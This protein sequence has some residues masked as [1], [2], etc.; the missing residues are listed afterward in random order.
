MLIVMDPELWTDTIEDYEA[1]IFNY[2]KLLSNYYSYREYST[3]TYSILNNQDSLSGLGVSPIVPERS[4]S[5][6]KNNAAL[7]H[8]SNI[9]RSMGSSVIQYPMAKL[10]YRTVDTHVATVLAQTA[11]DTKKTVTVEF[12]KI[13]ESHIKAYAEFLKEV[14]N[15]IKAGRKYIPYLLDDNG[16]VV[17]DSMGRPQPA[18]EREQ[19]ELGRYSKEYLLKDGKK[20]TKVNVYRWLEHL[21]SRSKPTI[22]YG[23]L[24]TKTERSSG[25]IKINDNYSVEKALIKGLSD[26]DVSRLLIYD[27]EKRI[28]VTQEFLGPA[29]FNWL[30]ENHPAW[31]MI[32]VEK[33]YNGGDHGM[34]EW[35]KLLYYMGL[36]P[37]RDVKDFSKLIYNRDFLISKKKNGE[38]IFKGFANIPFTPL[39][40]RNKSGIFSVA[41][42]FQLD[43]I[44]EQS[45][46]KTNGKEGG[47]AVRNSQLIELFI[48]FSGEG[49]TTYTER[50]KTGF[51][52]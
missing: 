4:I 41:Y 24:I 25:T 36:T 46:L 34:R 19:D 39:E 6:I 30:Q 15:S 51:S 52:K 49:Y 2:G 35:P 10:Y 37:E 31:L 45:K 33:N 43:N 11:V 42:A 26:L 48:R 7:M 21:D 28:K 14:E 18:F 3:E 47:F 27:I 44:A 20:N 13:P 50:A 16:D 1:F 29:R 40:L 5:T 23:H 38:Y 32:L 8:S 22:G 17:K 12:K 9:A